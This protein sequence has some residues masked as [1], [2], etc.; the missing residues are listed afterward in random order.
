MVRHDLAGFGHLFVK[1]GCCEGRTTTTTGGYLGFGFQLS[2]GVA[3]VRNTLRDIA[4]GYVVT[5]ADLGVFV[6]VIAIRFALLARNSEDK[7]PRRVFKRFLTKKDMRF[8]I[9]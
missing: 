8:Y 9:L 7:L 1:D 4:L 6:E 2:E 5:R 3:S